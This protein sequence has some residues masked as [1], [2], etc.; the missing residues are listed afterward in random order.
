MSD[1][2]MPPAVEAEGDRE[3]RWLLTAGGLLNAIA[4]FSAAPFLTLYLAGNSTL[5][6]PVI[7]AV[8]GSVALI[9]AFGGI[10][11]GMLVDRVGALRCVR[12]GLL[13]YIACYALLAAVAGTVALSIALIMLIGVGRLLV[14]PAMKK[15]LSLAS[16]ESGSIFRLRYITL[17]VGAIVGPAIGGLLYVAGPVY[18]FT[19]PAI[20][21]G[22]YFVLLLV[23]GRTIA[24]LETDVRTDEPS[25]EFPVRAALRDRRLMA[26]IGAGLV[27]FL[28]FSQIDSILPLYIKEEQEKAAVGYF[29]ALLIANAV[30]AIVLQAPIEWASSRIPERALVAI[31]CAAFA[32]AFLLFLALPVS[33]V[34]LYLGIVFWTIGEAVLLPMPDIAVHKLAADD[35]KGVYFGLAELRYLGFFA[36]PVL[37]GW[38]LGISPAV[39]FGICAVV[40][41]GCLPLLATAP[42]EPAKSADMP[43]PVSVEAPS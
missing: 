43:A 9:A 24:A 37:G 20:V 29:A 21:L 41:F 35:R 26:A 39:Y 2:A 11:G 3:A 12:A 27:I 7:G 40:V 10:L 22:L 4:F 19:C 42:A 1:D 25:V 38:L 34:F 6:K 16:G 17:C 33:I 32:I 13:I 23:R 15:L 5:S 30:L 28:V 31:G 8:V 18:L 14:E 36:G